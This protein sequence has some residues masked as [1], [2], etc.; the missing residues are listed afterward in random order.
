MVHP[1]S[2]FSRE[3]KRFD[4][5]AGGD[6]MEEGMSRAIPL[7][8]SRGATRAVAAPAWTERMTAGVWRVLEPPR[9]LW[10]ASLGATALSL[11][12][13]RDTWTLLVVEGAEVETQLWR[14][15]GR[16]ARTDRDG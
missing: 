15:L 7:R 9:Q 13:V 5:D 8:R 2:R 16:D 11:R 1:A 3:P 12:G 10:L 4:A 6:V 14:A